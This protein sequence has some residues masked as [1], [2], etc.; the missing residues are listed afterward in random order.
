M[1]T[2]LSLSLVMVS[3]VL[4]GGCRKQLVVPSATA[5]EAVA[6]PPVEPPAPPA[7]PSL[8]DPGTLT[9]EAPATF[10]AKFKTSRGEFVIEVTRA[11]A[12][13]G[14]DRFFNLVSEGFYNDVRF[15]RSIKGFMVQW[16]IS[17]DPNLNKIWRSATIAD[18]PVKQSNEPGFVTFA[19]S[20]PA[21]RT[22]QVFI[23][24]RLNAN[25]DK[26]G[27]A[28]FGKVVSGMKV[29]KNLF[30]GY[31]DGAPNGSGPDQERIQKEGNAYLDTAFPKLDRII[32]ASI[33]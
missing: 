20:G 17:G 11:W 3:L 12:P 8:L 27:F 31:G 2:K 9:A 15:F 25:L 5:T 4:V 32:K 24:H 22:T 16:G 6:T 23:N 1:Y 33:E 28:P 18:D 7:K 13:D 14:A 26:L 29:V 19:M 30:S 21:S 10:R